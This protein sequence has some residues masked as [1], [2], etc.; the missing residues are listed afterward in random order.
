MMVRRKY[1]IRLRDNDVFGWRCAIGV[2]VGSLLD[3][4]KGAVRIIHGRGRSA[5]LM[6]FLVLQQVVMSVE[7]LVARG[8]RTFEGWQINKKIEFCGSSIQC[9]HSRFS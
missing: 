9:Q 2:V 7:E 1:C 3:S 4:L 5:V 8:I 6:H